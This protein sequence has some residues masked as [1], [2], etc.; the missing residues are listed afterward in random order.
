LPLAIAS[1]G[2]SLPAAAQI[3]FARV[4]AYIPGTIGEYGATHRGEMMPRTNRAGHRLE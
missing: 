3:A 1:E 2:D 4:I